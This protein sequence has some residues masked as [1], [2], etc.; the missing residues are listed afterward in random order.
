MKGLLTAYAALSMLAFAA[1]LFL[2]RWDTVV[3]RDPERAL[4]EQSQRLV[5]RGLILASVN[6]FVAALV[7]VGLADGWI[8]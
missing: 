3:R 2:A 4:S 6:M 5:K 8:T 7:M 1:A